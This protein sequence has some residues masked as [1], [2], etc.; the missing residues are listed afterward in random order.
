MATKFGQA[1]KQVLKMRKLINIFM[2]LSLIEAGKLQLEVSKVSMLEI[3]M[4][5]VGDIQTVSP[6]AAIL[7]KG[8]DV[9]AFVDR[10][11]LEHVVLNLLSNA[12]KY[13]EPCS[14]IIVSLSSTLSDVSISVRD[15]GMGIPAAKLQKLFER[16]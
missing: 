9:E 11:K 14:E 1:E 6:N 15:Q 5:A 13:S 12:V 10:D 2:D 8:D 4:D 3:I 16:F 7:V